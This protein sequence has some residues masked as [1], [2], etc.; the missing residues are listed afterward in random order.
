MNNEVS[1]RF[2]EVQ[3]SRKK[4]VKEIEENKKKEEE[5]EEKQVEEIILA[6][7][8]VFE[9]A[10]KEKKWNSSIWQIC[11]EEEDEYLKCSIGVL[12]GDTIFY[13]VNELENTTLL[14]IV[15]SAM[16][17]LENIKLLKPEDIISNI[18]SYIKKGLEEGGI[19][20]VYY[21][22]VR[23]KDFVIIQML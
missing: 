15:E 1:K 11:I 22:Y 18:A 20:P 7:L 3:E 23:K 10:D 9:A 21:S 17:Y 5:A 2:Y 19:S 8:D 16:K 12:K 14:P 6:I 13:N 4:R